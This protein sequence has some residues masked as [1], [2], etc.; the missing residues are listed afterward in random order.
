MSSIWFSSERRKKL[1]K[2]SIDE[3][4]EKSIEEQ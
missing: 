2:K 3:F 4:P 1:K